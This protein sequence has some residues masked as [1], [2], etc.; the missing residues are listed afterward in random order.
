VWDR[1]TETEYGWRFGEGTGAATPLAWAQA[2]FVRLAHGIDAGRPVG[3]PR[4]V[5]ER[6]VGNETPTAPDLRVETRFV[7]GR[8]VVG[9]E[10]DAA[11]VAVRTPADAAL[12]E[13]E[14]GRFEAELAVESG[15]NLLTVAAATGR[16]I[17]SAGTAVV[18]RRL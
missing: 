6:Y 15:E 9:G 16:E 4:V 1:A 11:V 13:P 12:V 10:T 18:R 7:G 3:T 14:D 17:E 8:L 5:E 2:G